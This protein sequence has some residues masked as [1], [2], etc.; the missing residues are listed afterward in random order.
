[1]P[2]WLRDKVSKAKKGVPNLK[3][4]GKS[5]W[6]K[7]HHHSEETKRKIGLANG[8]KIRTEEQKERLRQ[9]RLGTKLSEEHKKKLSENNAHYWLGKKRPEMMGHRV[10]ERTIEHV[11]QLNKGKFGKEHPGWKEFK[12]KT[13]HQAL[14]QTYRYKD[15]RNKIFQ[16]D[17][18]TCVLCGKNKIY[19]EA[20]HNPKSFISIIDK[21]KIYTFDQAS[22]CEELWDINNGRTLCL[23]CHKNTDNYFFNSRHSR[24]NR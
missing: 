15:W 11:K 7:G 18:F 4:R 16:R 13:F 12:R 5:S 9:L 14:R 2:Q 23:P 19:L 21:N 3:L 10:S 6:I 20:D 8:L 1:M 24:H 22:S 17:G